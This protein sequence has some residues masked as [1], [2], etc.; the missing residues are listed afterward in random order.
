M[1]KGSYHQKGGLQVIDKS[2]PGSMLMFYCLIS[3]T[4][5]S[6]RISKSISNPF[7]KKFKFYASIIFQLYGV[8]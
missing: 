2:D 1:S 4:S 3:S 6:L 8:L 7:W 5:D